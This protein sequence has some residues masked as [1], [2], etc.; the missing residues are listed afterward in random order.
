M[1]LTDNF[2][3][4]E[5]VYSDTAQAK[6][7]DNSPSPLIVGRLADL[8]KKIL[9]PL[10]DAYG[11]PIRVNSGYRSPALNK[12]VGGSATSDHVNG[13]AAD[14]TAGGKIENMRLFNMIANLNLPFDQLI[15]EKGDKRV[16]PDWV[17]VSYNPERN[18]RQILYL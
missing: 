6:G 17:H 3:L 7:I 14:I 10:R 4:E 12:A 8:C 11:R 18:R 9:Q 15:F 1:K 16:G 5:L 13:R 2:T